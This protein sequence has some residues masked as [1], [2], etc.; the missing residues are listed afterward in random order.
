MR[1][2]LRSYWV[3]L[4]R[5]LRPQ[6]LRVVLLAVV[7]FGSIGV[8][9]VNPQIIGYFI[10]TAEQG[11][12]QQALLLAATLFIVMAFT[13]QLLA[14]G[15]TYLGESVGWNA[16][17]RLRT[18]LAAHCLR[19]DLSFHKARTPGELI[20]R[21]DGD[22]TLLSNFFSRF[23]IDV[24]GN[25]VLLAG[26][27]VLL[28]FEDWRVGLCLAAFALVAL[29]LLTRLRHLAVPIWAADREANAGF[30]GFLGERLAGTEDI[31]SS[32]ATG[33]TMRRFY[34]HLRGWA[35]L[36]RKAGLAG[37][38]MWVTTIAVFAVGDA[39]AFGLGAYLF[40]RG[41]ITL[42]TA[43]TIFYYT[44]LLGRPIEQIRSQLQDLQQA[45]ASIGRVRE[46]LAIQ[47]RVQ[48]G[49]GAA[50]PPGA[51]SV[52]FDLVTFGYE[53][54]DEPVLRDVSFRIEPGAVLG[55]LG[56]TGS[57]KTTIARLL[58]RLYD[59]QEGE[60]RIGG[61]PVKEPRLRDLRRRVGMVTQ[62]VQLF[63]ASVRDNLTFFN[64]EVPDGRILRV[65]DELG[66]GPWLRSLPT[67]LDTEL[68]SGGGLSAGESQLLAFARLFLLDPGL[69]ILDEASSRLDPA[70]EQLLERAMDRL[71]QGRTGIIIA[72]RLATVERA[73]EVMVMEGGRVVE[74]G[75]RAQLALAPDSRFAALLRTG[76]EVAA[77]AEG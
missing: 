7:L 23:V 31:R 53:E 9:L 67:G 6:R 35:P 34:E 5:Y 12:T 22:V 18:D 69:V 54:E 73:D 44:A 59:P 63:Q 1:I 19:L 33:Y 38:S 51:L 70:T 28:L 8:Q 46:L 25:A 41:A 39:V 29:L 57:G 11:G 49:P 61:V 37:S 72:H 66:L 45:D 50:L 13:Q 10:D 24:F 71:L 30:F 74:H 21:I 60:V 3:L 40:T 32:G 26:V 77:R 36:Q 17:N 27:L 75:P 2:P 68:A 14:V 62:D 55:L 16:T 4:A 20:E 52:E 47:S 58:F 65:L 56:H 76:L 42:G 15:A 64:R 48:D 43:Y